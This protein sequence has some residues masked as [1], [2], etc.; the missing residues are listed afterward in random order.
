LR[1]W[2]HYGGGVPGRLGLHEAAAAVVRPQHFRPNG[3]VKVEAAQQAHARCAQVAAP[4]LKA[5]SRRLTLTCEPRHQ[6]SLLW[7]GFSGQS[8]VVSEWK[9]A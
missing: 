1:S 4:R 8:N 9:R 7:I 3:C 5:L 6:K 2:L